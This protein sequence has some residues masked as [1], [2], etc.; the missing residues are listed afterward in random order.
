MSRYR[1][2]DHFDPGSGDMGC[3]AL[4]LLGVFAMPLVGLYLLFK[5]DADDGT[6]MLGGVLLVVGIIIWAYLSSHS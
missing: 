4:L 1:R 2:Q 6:K 5:K 3:L